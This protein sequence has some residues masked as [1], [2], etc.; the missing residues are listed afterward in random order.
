MVYQNREIGIEAHDIGDLSAEFRPYVQFDDKAELA[1][2]FPD[3]ASAIL[4]EALQINRRL[5]MRVKSRCNDLG[6]RLDEVG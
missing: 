4:R 2:G 6:L 3:D 5:P 1:R